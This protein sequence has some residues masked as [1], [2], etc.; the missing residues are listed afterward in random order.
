MTDVKIVTLAQNIN[1]IDNYIQI[2]E[3]NSIFKED[4]VLFTIGKYD[5]KSKYNVK[6]IAKYIKEK[7]IYKIPYNTMFS[8]DAPEGKIADYFF[9]FRRIKDT[10]LNA[11]FVTSVK[12]LTN[13]IVKKMKERQRKIY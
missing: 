6:N 10:H 3:N 9:K 13:E 8:M 5:D 11:D 4:N 1:K 7:S 2:K 12:D